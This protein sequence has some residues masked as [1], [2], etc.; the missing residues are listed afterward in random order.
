MTI[1]IS[2]MSFAQNKDS[3]FSKEWQEIDSLILKNNLPKTA[4]EK[5][6][7]VYKKAQA[8]HLPAEVIKALIYRISLQNTVQ[9]TDANNEII[10]L[11]N[12]INKNDNAAAKAIL[13]SIL[14]Q[15]YVEIYNRDRWRI[16][17]RSETILF[18]KED[19][20]T[21]SNKDF[22]N[23]INANFN[24]SLEPVMLLQK[25]SLNEFNAIIKAGNSRYLRPTLYDL[26]AHE[27]LN[28]YKNPIEPVT[29]P[30]F[31][32]TLNDPVIFATANEFAFHIFNSK[33]ST[34]SNLKAL[35]L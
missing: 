16:S 12:E 29:N 33:D 20:N 11:S 28:Y 17:Q 6:D 18:K 21:W 7:A 19:V 34:S 1:F 26:L 23:A 8:Q 10:E 27:A 4:L 31:A 2:T 24:T 30:A 5:V 25:I 13:H 35:K 9:E 32:F 3:I 14:A 15:K 22:L